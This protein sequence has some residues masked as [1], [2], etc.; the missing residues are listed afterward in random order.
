MSMSKSGGATGGAYFLGMIGAAIY[1]LGVATSF[2]MGV[3]AVLKA[4][5]RPV[6]VV[7]E[8]LKFLGA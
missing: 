3:L 2:W 1:Y 7:Y 8:L 5:V 6:F 4:I